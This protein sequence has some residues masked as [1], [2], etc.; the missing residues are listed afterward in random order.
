MTKEASSTIE[1]L[2]SYLKSKNTDI[3]IFINHW[4]DYPQK[5]RYISE[6]VAL[7]CE[8]NR[9]KE[10]IFLLADK[11]LHNFLKEVPTSNK[12]K[13]LFPIMHAFYYGQTL[14]VNYL[15]ENQTILV[16]YVTLERLVTHTK[17]GLA[18]YQKHSSLFKLV[19]AAGYNT[20]VACFRD[21]LKQLE[22]KTLEA[23]IPIMSNQSPLLLA[24]A[25]EKLLEP[26]TFKEEES[27]SIDEQASP[28]IS[29]PGNLGHEELKTEELPP[30][31][32]PPNISFTTLLSAINGGE[33]QT[34]NRDLALADKKVILEEENALAYLA[35]AFLATW[36]LGKWV[37]KDKG[38]IHSIH[39]NRD[40]V[41][42]G[43]SLTNFDKFEM[44]EQLFNYIDEKLF[45]QLSKGCDHLNPSE[46]K[47]WYVKKINQQGTHF[48]FDPSDDSDSDDEAKNCSV[49]KKRHYEEMAT[50]HNDTFWKKTQRE[51][52]SKQKKIPSSQG[53]YTLKLKESLKKKLKE[54]AELPVANLDKPVFIPAFR[55]NNYLEDR[56]SNAQ[57]RQHYHLD[58]VGQPHYSESA[59]MAAGNFYQEEKFFSPEK[60]LKMDETALSIQNSHYQLN[61]TGPCLAL[62]KKPGQ[63]LF[64]FNSFGDYLQHH[65]SNGISD[66]LKQL[67]GM[68]KV[69]DKWLS[70]SFANAY[71]YAI[72]ASDRPYHSLRYAL[73][74]KE[75]YHH[76]FTPRYN[77]D[78]SI[79]NVH[80]GKLYI[81]LFTKEDMLDPQLVNRVNSMLQ[82]GKCP[83]LRDIS[84]EVET[85]LFGKVD[86]KHVVYQ[87]QLRFPSFNKAYK[88]IYLT[89]YGMDK[90]LYAL[91]QSLFNSCT[92]KYTSEDKS[93]YDEVVDLLKEWL[94]AYYEVM[95]LKMA[96]TIAIKKGG[97]LMYFNENNQ[98]SC[99]PPQR[100]LVN[101][102][103]NLPARRKMH[104]LEETRRY[105]AGKLM[106][107]TETMDDSSIKF[108]ETDLKA[109]VQKLLL[110]SDELL[111][112]AKGVDYYKLQ[113]TLVEAEEVNQRCLKEKIRQDQVLDDLYTRV[114]RQILS[115][116]LESFDTGE[117][118][119]SQP[120]RLFSWAAPNS[121]K[122]QDAESMSRYYN[123]NG[124]N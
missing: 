112:I 97:D 89:K 85:T 8:Q 42:Q 32:R 47:T 124:F 123:N 31:Q 69:K 102:L 1:S 118:K 92:F 111:K 33:K 56:W 75:Y 10:L 110:S 45:T 29:S 88:S 81:F 80:A 64:V 24:S 13:N 58:E 30:V 108:I 70:Q 119:T 34:F 40:A 50:L 22:H 117:A 87:F 99:K 38:R 74:L 63:E 49:G 39:M 25:E 107:S 121:E 57:K 98:L 21:I 122:F 16:K 59:M 4:E 71:N 95:A 35:S 116:N 3:A 114:V 96:R 23:I 103:E 2:K 41:L 91:F 86:P 78:G 52:L 11:S 46:V 61:Q 68:L 26:P 77:R 20:K 82:N 18:D 105:I 67:V 83:V 6:I 84:S 48:S 19:S 17:E 54:R 14:C 90:Q 76:P 106:P 15:I 27:S 109:E 5:K 43:K 72:S 94:C 7:A 115:S 113:L 28:F 120:Q 62:T 9:V 12:K 65:Y 66:H 104:V 36:K 51:V 55:G 79:K 93:K 60:R 101:G 73:G 44:I 53:T 100:P 37:I